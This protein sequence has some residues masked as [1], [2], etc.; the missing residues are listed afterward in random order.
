MLGEIFRGGRL[1]RS[2]EN[3]TDF[4]GCIVVFLGLG[5][6]ILVQGYIPSVKC[7]FSLGIH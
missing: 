4:R 7:P 3:L 1:G 2:S 5:E 6:V